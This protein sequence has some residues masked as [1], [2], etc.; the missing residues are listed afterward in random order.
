MKNIFA[1]NKMILI[2]LLC[3]MISGCSKNHE[4][5]LREQPHLYWKDIDVEVID[6]DKRHWFASTHWYQVDLEVYSS[7]Y[8][9][10]KTFEIQGSGAFGCPKEFDYEKGDIL[11]AEL[12]SWKKDST[13]EIV[14]REIHK[15]K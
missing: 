2:I 10:T 12:Y 7:E 15:L 13:E 9:L 14:K 4:N 5:E 3:S 8:D 1:L 6:I 11:K